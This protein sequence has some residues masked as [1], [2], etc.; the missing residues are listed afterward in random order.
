MNDSSD[1]KLPDNEIKKRKKHLIFTYVFCLVSIGFIYL[2]LFQLVNFK[3][4][5]GRFYSFFPYY[6]Y[7]FLLRPIFYLCIPLLIFHFLSVGH[8]IS[9]IHPSKRRFVLFL[10]LLIIVLYYIS[11]SVSFLNLVPLLGGFMYD[12]VLMPFFN[13]PALFIIPGSLLFFGL[14]K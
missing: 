9:M 14:N 5:T 4:I 2:E 1:I 13:L 10:G 7:I 12:Y 3:I 6:F 8:D 11:V